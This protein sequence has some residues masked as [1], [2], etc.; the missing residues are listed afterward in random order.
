MSSIWLSD[1]QYN[2]RKRYTKS[3]SKSDLKPSSSRTN[4]KSCINNT[5]A[6]RSDEDFWQ[7]KILHTFAVIQVSRVGN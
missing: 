1:H 4:Q 6:V 5:L 2:P 3:E 7:R